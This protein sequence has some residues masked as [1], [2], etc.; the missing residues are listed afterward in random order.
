MKYVIYS[1]DLINGGEPASQIG[2]SGATFEGGYE[3]QHGRFLG[4]LLG[5]DEQCQAALESCSSFGMAEITKEQA[6]ARS[7]Y[8]LPINTEMQHPS[9]EHQ[10]EIFYA[11]LPSIDDAGRIIRGLMAEPVA[12]PLPDYAIYFLDPETQIIKA[13]GVHEA[14]IRLGVQYA[15]PVP[16]TDTIIINGVSQTVELTNGVAVITVT[17]PTQVV[18]FYEYHDLMAI[19]EAK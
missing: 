3:E 13:N 15:V 11:G 2:L 16:E 10:G 19:V 5:T 7:V 9:A 14:H 12:A 17:S 4:Y 6:I 1:L 8:I 18:M